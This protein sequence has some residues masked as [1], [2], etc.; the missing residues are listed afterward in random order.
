[1]GKVPVVTKYQGCHRSEV[2]I[3]LVHELTPTLLSNSNTEPMTPFLVKTFLTLFVVIDPVGLIPLFMTL[4]G[5][6]PPEEQAQIARRAVLI[7][8]AILTV[9]SL[10]GTLL[11]NY[12]GV[13][14]EAF[15]IAAGILLFKI[16]LDMV[17]GHL[18]RET[19]E[20]AEE[21]ATRQDVSVFPLAIPLIAGP[22][23]LA[24]LLVLS[25]EMDAY[26]WG[27]GVILA[28]AGVVLIITYVLLRFSGYLAKLLGQTG[29]SA[30]TRVLGIL[31]CALAVQ[32]IADGAVSL[33]NS[34]SHIKIV[35][36]Q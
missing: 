31:L 22:G 5:N 24:S 29:V 30:T 12:L 8:A 1:M 6:Q 34:A 25:S 19:P 14:L 27:V 7:S 35:L 10:S 23:T 4:A 18:E 21:A 17:F 9:F 33:F 28:I 13:T 36:P 3:I 16:A 11:L 2:W 26:P 20:E 32:Y 15:Q